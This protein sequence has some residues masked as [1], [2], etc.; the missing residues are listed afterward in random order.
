MRKPSQVV[1]IACS[2]VLFCAPDLSAQPVSR[3]DQTA[4]A[5]I[6]DGVI[7][8]GDYAGESAGINSGFGGVLGAATLGVDA[9]AVGNLVWSLSGSTGDCA[10]NNHVVIYIDSK[11]GGISS[12]SALTDTSDPGRRAISGSNVN[13]DAHL[14]FAPGFAPDY[15]LVLT[16]SFVGTF[17][18]DAQ[19]LTFGE[20]LTASSSFV[21]QNCDVEIAGSSATKFGARA[22]APIRYVATLLNPD[23][24]AGPFR[25]DEFHG[26][27]AATVPAG[28]PGQGTVTLGASDFNT[29][30]TPLVLINEVDADTPGSD[31]EEFVEL[32]TTPP[33]MDMSGLVLVAYNGSDDSSYLITGQGG[34]E[35]SGTSN[36][37]GL[38]VA[39]SASV[40]NVDQVIGDMLPTPS[41]SFI[42]NGAD[43]LAIYVDAASSFPNDSNIT[44]SNLVDAVVY[45]TSDS[46][47]M[48][49]ISGL[50]ASTQEPQVD[51]NKNANKD[52]DSSQRCEPGARQTRSFIVSAPTPGSLNAACVCLTNS[53]C[54][55]CETCDTMTNKCAPAPPG[56]AC[57]EDSNAC[58]LDTCDASG[59][60]IRGGTIDCS[61][62]A[63]ECNVG[64]CDPV[65]GQCAPVPSNEG[66]SC[67]DGD[68]CTTMTACVAGACVNGSNT[69]ECQR[70]AD[71]AMFE[72]GNTCNGVLVCNASN[73]CVVDP[74]TIITC[75]T[76][77][78]TACMENLCVPATGECVMQPANIGSGCDDQNICTTNETCDASGDCVG[79]AVTDGTACE[80]D[81]DRCTPDT[82][83]AGL[84]EATSSPL[85]CSG[86]D[87]ACSVGVC[88]DTSGACV[89]APVSDGTA[90]DDGDACTEGDACDSGTCLPGTTNVCGEDMGQRPTADM[91]TSPPPEREDM[92]HE[93]GVGAEMG[94]SDMGGRVT[95]PVDVDA[96]GCSCSSAGINPSDAMW[97][98][99]LLGFFGLRRREH[100]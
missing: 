61:S 28:N 87:G 71:C 96:T 49:L 86:L 16:R 7:A 14:N 18:L 88:D 94:A 97:P 25:S 3:V 75:D 52:F 2:A 83:Q 68:A 46:D 51:E 69:C 34:I 35:L 99:L 19:G 66:M 82:C 80:L 40:P 10:G 91:G 45:G 50:L 43:A 93:L 60:C 78:N 17:S 9:D 12:T 13:G 36:A 20:D 92:G 33:N 59:A 84:C 64:A 8:S 38:F 29:F 47:D 53:D 62:S 23:D 90:C 42:Q 63:D 44:T 72:D 70:D 85:D 65:T 26:V 48:G 54:D 4:S 67:D 89:S 100:E 98:L 27:A 77:T 6:A 73:Q 1:A 41:Q 22:G 79:V 57:D 11:A 5:P 55:V 39:G 56:S 58:T 30:T 31:S 21:G 81:Q 74:S 24:A 15:A 37:E 95:D 32:V 76:S